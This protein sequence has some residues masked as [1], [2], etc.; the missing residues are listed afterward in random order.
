[1]G[2][3]VKIGRDKKCSADGCRICSVR[4]NGS[5][6]RETVRMLQSTS[7]QPLLLQL[8]EPCPELTES[9]PLSASLISLESQ[10]PLLSCISKTAVE[11]D[12]RAHEPV[13]CT[14]GNDTTFLQGQ[15]NTTIVQ[16][17]TT[18]TM[19]LLQSQYN[20]TFGSTAHSSGNTTTALNNSKAIGSNNGEGSGSGSGS[21]EGDSKLS[22]QYRIEEL[23]AQLDKMDETYDPDYINA[24]VNPVD[25][26]NILSLM[27]LRDWKQR[28][29]GT[30]WQVYSF[31]SYRLYIH[32]ANDRYALLLCT[33]AK[34]PS[35]LAVSRLDSLCSILA[36][37]L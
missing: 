24:N 29:E 32:E 6:R 2:K 9:L 28:A 8:L 14:E 25:N 21:A 15:G 37:K 11:Q 3:V 23:Q 16:G 31:G 27:V 30:Q 18:E 20:T 36:N 22:P 26:L 19:P 12:K 13:T 33:S 5:K 34:Y 1:M 7:L 35:A 17:D 10:K 4:I